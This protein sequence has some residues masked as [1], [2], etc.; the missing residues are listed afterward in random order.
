MSER[1]EVV[2]TDGYPEVDTP[3]YEAEVSVIDHADS[4][5]VVAV[6]YVH[7]IR[8]PPA[9][10]HRFARSGFSIRLREAEMK[11]RQHCSKLNAEERA[12][13]ATG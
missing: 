6:F 9:S 3:E 7:A 10:D 4:C 8:R 13:E 2:T 12:W 1:Y 11:A 5:K